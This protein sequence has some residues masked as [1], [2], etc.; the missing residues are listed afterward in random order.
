VDTSSDVSVS[1]RCHNVG[2]SSPSTSARRRVEVV[3]C[4]ILWPAGRQHWRA[5]P[6]ALFEIA[7]RDLGNVPVE[8]ADRGRRPNCTASA[9]QPGR[10]LP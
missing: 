1:G 3:P 6:N 7:D 5:T 10:L 8:I 2:H 9:G 4:R